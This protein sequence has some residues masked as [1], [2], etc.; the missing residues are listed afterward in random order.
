MANHPNR[1]IYKIGIIATTMGRTQPSYAVL[2]RH[3]DGSYSTYLRHTDRGDVRTRVEKHHT[4]GEAKR[5][6]DSLEVMA[7]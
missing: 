6:F 2:E 1:S 3:Q 7:S 4:Y 5:R